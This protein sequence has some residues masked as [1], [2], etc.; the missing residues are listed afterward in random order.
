M[1][2]T[3]QLNPETWDLQVNNNND[4]AVAANPNGLAQTAACAIKLFLGEYYWDTT[5]GIPYLTKILG[6]APPLA[7]LKQ[8]PL[9]AALGSDP[10]IASAQVFI[11]SFDTTRGL[12]G[13]VQVISTTGALGVAN[14]TVLNPQGSG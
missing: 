1:T 4:P 9:N 14:F 2:A 10:D 7:T 6:Q 3:L 8:Y 5:K 11:S 13:Q 12:T